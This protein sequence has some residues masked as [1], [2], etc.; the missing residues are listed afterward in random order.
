M[1][2]E[3]EAFEGKKGHLAVTPGAVLF[4]L[5]PQHLEQAHHCLR[6]SGEIRLSFRELTVKSLTEIREL[7][8]DGG[9]TVD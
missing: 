2:K 1:D 9:V 6:R 4:S 8:G 5:T 3:H 7:N